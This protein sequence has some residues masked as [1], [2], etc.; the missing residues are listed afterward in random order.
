M[1]FSGF[2]LILFN[3][4]TSNLDEST[5]CTLGNFTGTKLFGVAN[6]RGLCCHSE[7]PRQAGKIGRE[8]HHGVQH[9]QASGD[10]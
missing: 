9:E 10:E 5:E 3:L 7:R 4:I 6:S 8:E 2:V 1:V